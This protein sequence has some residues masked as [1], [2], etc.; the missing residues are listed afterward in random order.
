MFTPLGP[1]I[2]GARIIRVIAV[3]R[4]IYVRIDI[5]EHPPDHMA[6]ALQNLGMLAD[7]LARIADHP[8]IALLMSISG[9]AI[10]A[11]RVWHAEAFGPMDPDQIMRLVIPSA[12]LILPASQIGYSSFFINLLASPARGFRWMKQNANERNQTC[13]HCRTG[14]LHQHA[15][16]RP[17]AVQTS[18]TGHP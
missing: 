8:A 13:R 7:V 18:W 16:G 14:Y 4:H 5:S 3:N 9:L 10:A 2:H 17:G 1:A 15:R 12:T 11:F 6:L